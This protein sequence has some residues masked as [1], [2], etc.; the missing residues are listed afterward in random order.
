MEAYLVPLEGSVSWDVNWEYIYGE[1]PAG[2]Y[3]LVK[4]FNN[5][6]GPGDSET[7]EL[8]VDFAIK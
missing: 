3:R 8:F 2:N 1:L 6:K 4:T 5:F 7:E